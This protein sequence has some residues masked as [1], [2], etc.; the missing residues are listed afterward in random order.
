MTLTKRRW[1]RQVDDHPLVK[2]WRRLPL[3]ALEDRIGLIRRTAAQH[4]L[5][6]YY[7]K[8]LDRMRARTEAARRGVISPR[9]APLH[10]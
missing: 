10:Q 8:T 7:W 9:P 3:A 1:Q 4:H 2:N 5:N 6:L